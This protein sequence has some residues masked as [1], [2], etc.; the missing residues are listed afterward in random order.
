MSLTPAVLDALLAAGATADMIVAAV[1]A[2]MAEAEARKETKRAGNAERQRRFKAKRKATRDNAGNALPDVTPSPNDIYSNPHPASSEPN[3]SPEAKPRRAKADPFPI[4]DGVDP[5]DWDALKANR[6]SKR[7]AL[8]EGA[9]REIIRK[10]DVWSRAGWPPGPIVAH[11]A[12]RGWTTVFEPDEMKAAG[13]GKSLHGR[14]I[15]GSG[16]G[17]ADRRDGFERACDRLIERAE[18]GRPADGG[19]GG[20]SQR[21]LAAPRAL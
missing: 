7:A 5:I 10:L 19:I 6:K 11:A 20:G 1:K 18:A 21:A 17:G 16:S 13:N 4:P 15:D 8:T 14:R 12:E 3:G 2:D 9:H